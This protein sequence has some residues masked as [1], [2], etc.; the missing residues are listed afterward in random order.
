MTGTR[1]RTVRPGLALCALTLAVSAV[2]LGSTIL[3][4]A[5][6]TMQRDLGASNTEQQWFLN[7][8]T[9]TFAGFLLVGGSAGD[10]FGLRRLLV[11]GTAA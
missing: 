4:V 5:L 3:N 2:L 7:S 8:Y 6:P 1:G 9:L 11:W 10:R